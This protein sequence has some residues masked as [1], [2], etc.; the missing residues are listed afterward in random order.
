MTHG[1]VSRLAGEREQRHIDE[2]GHLRLVVVAFV[3]IDLD[4]SA[5]QERHDVA[6]ALG[7]FGGRMLGRLVATQHSDK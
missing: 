5:L 1:I 6:H 3:K 4:A 7:A 2:C